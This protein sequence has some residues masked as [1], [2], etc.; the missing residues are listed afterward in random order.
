MHLESKA[1]ATLSNYESQDLIRR[2]YESINGRQANAAQ[3]REIRSAFS[4]ARNYFEAARTSARNVKP[5]LLYYGVIGLSRALVM[6]RSDL[7]EAHLDQSH[8]L[9][10]RGWQ[11]I[12]SS[13]TPD[14]AKIIIRINNK[15]TLR[16]FVNATGNK[17][18]LKIDSSG[19]QLAYPHGLLPPSIE[20]SFDDIISRFPEIANQY[21]RWQPA[22]NV[23]RCDISRQGD[24]TIYRFYKNQFGNEIARFRAEAF[25]EGSPV[26]Y[27]REDDGS[28]YYGGST[29]FKSMP[30]LSDQYNSS[31]DIIGSL[32]VIKPY[33]CGCE[34][35][36]PA[37]TFIMSYA[38]GMLARYFPSR[39]HS[40]LSG[41]TG[42]AGLPTLLAAINFIE[43]YFPEMILSFLEDSLPT[44]ER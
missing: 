35:S 16:E 32:A 29:N 39:W 12:F 11:S 19:F 40:M 6:M 27:I 13:A 14:I 30:P 15:G 4:Q 44:A 37:T 42:D 1:W 34:I 17:S 38:L 7:R 36:K 24:L 5:L 33:I 2:R 28:I 21:S 31:F 20:I 43:V 41:E 22:P 18:H 25:I 26:A 10:A 23:A 9:S 3:A 8:G